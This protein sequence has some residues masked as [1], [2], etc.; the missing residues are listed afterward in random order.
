L[1]TGGERWDWKFKNEG[2]DEE[3]KSMQTENGGRGGEARMD[4]NTMDGRNC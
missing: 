1:G 3:A 4:Q 2:Q